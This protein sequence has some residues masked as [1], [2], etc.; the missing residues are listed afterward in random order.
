[1]GQVGLARM[2]SVLIAL[3]F[4]LGGYEITGPYGTFTLRVCNNTE[5]PAMLAIIGKRI[6]PAEVVA[7]GAAVDQ[8]RRH[9]DLLCCSQSLSSS[10]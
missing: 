5:D 3:S 7:L 1:M 8:V 6:G 10:S 9:V 4:L 2:G